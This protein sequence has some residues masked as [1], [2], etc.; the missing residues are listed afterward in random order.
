MV[1][2]YRFEG[3]GQILLSFAIEEYKDQEL[4]LKVN[5]KN[6]HLIKWYNRNK[7]RIVRKYKTED[8]FWMRKKPTKKVV[9]IL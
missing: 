7:F 4:Y 6:I 8:Y 5:K 1:P 9:N 3:Y 2:E